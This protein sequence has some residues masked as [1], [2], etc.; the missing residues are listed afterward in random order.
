MVL[1]RPAEQ[2]I[3]PNPRYRVSG[4]N[5]MVRVRDTSLLIASVLSAELGPCRYLIRRK[6]AYRRRE[7]L[8]V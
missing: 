4:H 1:I 6:A 8:R 7:S 5:T 2:K 3:R